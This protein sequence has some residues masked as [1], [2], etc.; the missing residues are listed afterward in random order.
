MSFQS[1]ACYFLSDGLFEALGRKARQGIAQKSR[2]HRFSDQKK[3]AGEFPLEGKVYLVHQGSVF[4]SSIDENGKKIILDILGKGGVFGDLD[5]TNQKDYTDFNFF[6][7]PFPKAAICQ[8]DKKSFVEILRSNPDFTIKLLSD[9]AKRLTRLEERVGQ[10]QYADVSTRLL[11]QLIRLSQDF[12]KKEEEK[13]VIEKRLTHEQLAEMIGSTRETVSSVISDL[14][15]QKILSQNQKHHFCLDK[16]K[17]N[18][19]FGGV[20]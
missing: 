2:M 6:V 3:K 19:V 20:F 7:E 13:I 15:Q 11:A 5:F 9:L 1:Q 16:K 10:L 12:G 18:A 14:R 8:M 17:T 4:L